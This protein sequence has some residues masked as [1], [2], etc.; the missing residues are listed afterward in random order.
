MKVNKSVVAVAAAVMTFAAA[1]CG[2]KKKEAATPPPASTVAD[3]ALSSTL[4]LSIP[5]K[6]AAASGGTAATTLN[7]AEELNLAGK[8]S[9]EACRTME[10]V[11]QVL[12]QLKEIGVNFCH[13]EV[14]SENL[15]FGTKYNIKMTGGSRTLAESDSMGIWVDNSDTAK[16]K[17][18]MCRNGILNQQ[19][20]ISDFASAG[21]AKGSMNTL[22]SG[23][24]RDG[25]S[26]YEGGVNITFDLTQAGL[27]IVNASMKHKNTG[28]SDAGEFRN[29]ADISLADTGVSV[30]KMTSKGS[31]GSDTMSDQAAV[32]FNGTFG[33]ALFSGT[34]SSGV[35]TY[36][37]SSASTFGA[38]G[39][40]VAKTS[41]PSDVLVEAADL[42]VK[43]ADDFSPTTPTGWDCQTTETLTI[44]MTVASKKAA[45]D[46]CSAD[47]RR[48][49]SSCW[50]D[51]FEQGTHEAKK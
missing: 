43:L 48:S 11:S 4:N 25:V 15:K 5:D 1:S 37:Y 12:D 40:T 46:A 33:Q 50:G 29:S 23:T 31:H 21:K 51:D 17:V 7:L 2:K 14:E 27:K 8:K 22:H 20:S 49:F 47:R 35:H 10:T 16:L 30:V 45:H 42:P 32:R 39:I 38:D 18:Y 24:G 26:T 36:D 6:L 13:F 44:D 3:L 41:A 34:G 19:I 9:S 28:G